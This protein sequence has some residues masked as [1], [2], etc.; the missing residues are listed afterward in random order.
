[1]GPQRATGRSGACGWRANWKLAK[2]GALDNGVGS[3]RT[4]AAKFAALDRRVVLFGR[5]TAA[6]LVI[7]AIA[8]AIARYL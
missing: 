7:S 1:M 8:M 3:S 6:L 4:D 2:L 5:L